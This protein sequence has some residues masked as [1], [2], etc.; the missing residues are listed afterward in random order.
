MEQSKPAGEWVILE[1]MGHNRVAGLYFFENGLHRVDV[2]DTIN[3]GQ[4]TRTERYGPG[5]IFRITSVDKETACL[6]AATTVIPD[7]VPFDVRRHIRQLVAP[8]ETV[9]QLEF[10]PD[11]DD[12][13]DDDLDPY[14]YK[15]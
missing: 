13:E 14:D 5:S 12:E 4:F 10:Q 3:P 15:D 8:R 2:P 11:T 6:V 7:A 1:A 9:E